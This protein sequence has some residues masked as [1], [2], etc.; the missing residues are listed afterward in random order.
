MAFRR[1]PGLRSVLFAVCSLLLAPI[2]HT[3][4]DSIEDGDEEAE[5]GSVTTTMEPP[6]EHRDG[7]ISPQEKAVQGKRVK[8][9]RKL[10]KSH[11]WREDD[12]IEVFNA[13]FLLASWVL[14]HAPWNAYH[15]GLAFRNNRTGHKC[16]YD[17]TPDD[18]SS[19][20]RMVLPEVH[21]PKGLFRAAF[22]GEVEFDW[23]DEA[24]MEFYIG[25]WPGH[26]TN[27]VKLGQFNGS[28]L[29]KFADW[30]VS[31][32]MD[33]FT[34]FNPVEV[35]VPE[36]IKKEGQTSI[37]SRMCHDF[38]TDSLWMLYESGA[39]LKAEH[40]VFRDHIIM[41]A[42]K[43]DK[44]DADTGFKKKELRYLRSLFL[45]L[46]K[47][48]QQFTHAREAL[49]ALWRLRVPIF[50]HDYKG[51]YHQVQIVPP[52][53]NYCYLP[54]AIPPEQYNP[55][56]ATKLC[57]LGMEANLTNTTSPWPMGPLLA[58]EDRLDQATPLTAL[59]ITAVVVALS[60][61]QQKKPTPHDGQIT[62]PGG[63]AS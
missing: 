31:D 8:A 11:D 34:A 29:L 63:K 4:E 3:V 10:L 59:L 43:I 52:F 18:T 2:G 7:V 22:F 20:M 25:D 44:M 45:Y 60:T 55:F 14:D 32:Y 53:L 62:K 37:R 23:H 16:L 39:K 58:A 12:I 46:N 6:V 30:V 5:D 24:H 17:F 40:V 47:I 33:N 15:S 26:Y 42:E 9:A 1:T 21:M 35:V 54:L 28:L 19:V 13:E 36:A 56:G 27:F 49:L 50:V 48:K 38:V 41:Y 51:D 57:A 61:G